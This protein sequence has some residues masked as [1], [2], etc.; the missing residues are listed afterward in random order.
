M[1]HL[2]TF[3]FFF[4]MCDYRNCTGHCEYQLTY[5][6]MQM[7]NETTCLM[8]CAKHFA[9]MKI[10]FARY[11]NIQSSKYEKNAWRE[12]FMSYLN[13]TARQKCNYSL[14]SCL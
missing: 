2:L 9:F 10:L 5:D 4:S 1:N 3:F 6:P 7:T 13:Q 11:N 8:F 12:L 14:F